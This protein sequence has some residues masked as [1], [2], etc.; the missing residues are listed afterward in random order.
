[1]A[2]PAGRFVE[3]AGDGSGELRGSG[4][5]RPPR[6][7]PRRVSVNFPSLRSRRCAL[8]RAAKIGVP[9]NAGG[10]PVLLWCWGIRRGGSAL[11]Q[12]PQL[13]PSSTRGLATPVVGSDLNPRA[14]P[15]TARKWFPAA[16]PSERQEGGA[17]RLRA[18]RLR[19]PVTCCTARREAVVVDARWRGLPLAKHDSCHNPCFLRRDPTPVP[20]DSRLPASSGE[21]TAMPFNIT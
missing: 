5:W 13:S 4:P 17:P 1:M 2:T 9:R 19:Q 15:E 8:F 11:S 21:R 3:A 16:F 10:T 7:M 12:M 14:A 18:C 6:P 20:G